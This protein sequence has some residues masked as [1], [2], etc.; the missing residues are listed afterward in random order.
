MDLSEPSA[1]YPNLSSSTA[2]F[3]PSVPRRHPHHIVHI[4]HQFVIVGRSLRP[5]D[6]FEITPPP[7]P[8]FIV[9]YPPSSRSSS[10]RQIV[11]ELFR[12]P[13]YWD[14]L[15]LEPFFITFANLGI[16]RYAKYI[17]WVLHLF[18]VNNKTVLLVPTSR[19]L[20]QVPS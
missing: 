8:A 13:F 20:L 6:I 17:I 15:T 18:Y 4:T 1:L 16:L 14:F 9:P 19:F 3:R 11:K 10:S 5:P 12:K 2:H 7:P